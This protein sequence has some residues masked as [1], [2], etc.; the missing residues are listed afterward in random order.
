MTEETQ[1]SQLQAR[2][3]IIDDDPILCQLLT[4]LLSM[5]GMDVEAATSG[6]AGIEVMYRMKPDLVLLDI[7]MPEVDGWEIT[8]RIREVADVPII[9]ISAL[10]RTEDIV[11]SLE[12]GADDFIN[13]PFEVEELLARIRALQRRA[14]SFGGPPEYAHDYDDGYLAFNI[15]AKQ[16]Y[17]SGE[18]VYLSATEYKL[19]EFLFRRSGKV[20]ANPDL[21]EHV[22]GGL[23]PNGSRYLHVYIWKLR[24]KIEPDTS[25]PV[26]FQTEHGTGYRFE[27]QQQ[28]KI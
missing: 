19:F 1:E 9:I 23:V 18:E 8:Q 24:N 14:V 6:E 17:L 26:Y 15:P 28:V 21:L 11:R 2:I 16:V 27:R 22:W 20:C 4:T 10:S 12:S 5:E 3:L 13:K 7:M 25:Q